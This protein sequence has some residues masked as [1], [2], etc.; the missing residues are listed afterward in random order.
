M[1]LTLA[2][3]GQKIAHTI[4]SFTLSPRSVPT[5]TFHIRE[6]TVPVGNDRTRDLLT[7]CDLLMQSFPDITAEID[8]YV[9]AVKP[10]RRSMT[11]DAEEFLDWL[12]RRPNLS[13]AQRDTII[14]QQSRFTIEFV[15]MKQQ[16]AHVRFQELLSNNA[17]LADEL[18]RNGCI[19]VHLNPA[20]VWASLDTH[21]FVDELTP[22]PAR[23]LFYQVARSIQGAVIED[24]LMPLL[25]Q[26]REMP[27]RVRNLRW[28][29][30]QLSH[31]EF[32][33]VLRELARLGIIALG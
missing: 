15:A 9:S 18:P 26:L 2:S 32:I 22:V 6:V 33:A 7:S 17:R 11:E 27:Q 23:I 24:D 25:N 4:R 1:S 29:L 13:D 31:I 14:C 12:A 8:N 20:H 21:T 3:F 30:S 28:T 5:A 10:Y 19:F 16:L